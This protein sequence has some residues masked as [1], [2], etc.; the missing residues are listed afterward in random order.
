MTTGTPYKTAGDEVRAIVRNLYDGTI[1]PGNPAMVFYDIVDHLDEPDPLWEMAN[2]CLKI[3]FINPSIVVRVNRPS[4]G[5]HCHLVLNTIDANSR[6]HWEYKFGTGN[7]PVTV[8]KCDHDAWVE[9]H[10]LD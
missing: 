6:P 5:D 8:V 9:I 1:K 4:H 7:A 10:V 3:G 2:E